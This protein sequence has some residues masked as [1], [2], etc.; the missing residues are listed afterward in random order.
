MSKCQDQI[1]IRPFAVTSI[2]ASDDDSDV[3]NADGSFSDVSSAVGDLHGDGDDEDYLPATP[4]GI[5]N[6]D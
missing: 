3:K 1:K 2:Y 5:D 4:K 6:E